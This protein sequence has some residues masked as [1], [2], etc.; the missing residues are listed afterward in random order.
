MVFEMISGI[1]WK[2]LP[3]LDSSCNFI[4]AVWSIF[5]GIGFVTAE[6]QYSCVR[7]LL[8]NAEAKNPLRPKTPDVA[9]ME[10]TEVHY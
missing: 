6:I 7:R 2:K 5:S 10:E 8:Q 9:C 3:N 4:C 1:G